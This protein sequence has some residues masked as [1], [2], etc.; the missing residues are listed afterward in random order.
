MLQPIIKNFRQIEAK[1][2]VFEYSY[3]DCS[4]HRPGR[5]DRRDKIKESVERRRV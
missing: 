5:K 1:I 2:L 4:E 3:M